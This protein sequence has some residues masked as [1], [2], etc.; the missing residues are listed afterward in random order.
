[1]QDAARPDADQIAELF[2]ELA[3]LDRDQRQRVYLERAVR[4]AVRDEVEA[5]L[6]EPPLAAF[7][8]E[9]LSSAG[10][11]LVGECE[12]RAAP[13]EPG[14]EIG[15]YKIVREIARGGMGVVYEAEQR[16]LTR[17]VALKVIRGARFADDAEQQ[18][19]QVE[20][21]AIARLD[22]SGIVPVYEVAQHDEHPFFTMAYV[23]GGS[24]KDVEVPMAPRPA[25]EL[26][27]K[28]CDAIHYAHTQNIVHRDL[29]PAN[30]LLTE[31]LQP[32]VSDFG[33]AKD[34]EDDSDLTYTGAI[35][36]TPGF[37]APEQAMGRNEA[38]GH[39]A[40]VYGLGGVLFYLLT[41]RP[42][43]EGES[44]P[45]TLHKVV[46]DE[47]PDP[48]RLVASV[49]LDLAGI[50]RKAMEK[51][52]ADRYG[53]A[54]GLAEDLRRYLSGH[55]TVARPLGAMQRAFRWCRRR[56]AI[57]S[58]AALTVIA[59]LVGSITSY[60]FAK[61]AGA[62]ANELQA[63]NK[64]L[65]NRNQELAA[66]RDAATQAQQD[67]ESFSRFLVDDVMRRA[68]PV[69]SV[70]GMG[71]DVT[72]R[73]AL[74]RAIPHLATRF[75]GNPLA[76]ALARSEL[77]IT[78]RH[79]EASQEAV[80]Q[81]KLAH[82][83]RLREL[84][85]TDALTISTQNSLGVA[86][87]DDGRFEDAV[88]VF[89]DLRDIVMAEGHPLL[90]RVLTNLGECYEKQGRHADTLQVLQQARGHAAD[91]V[92]R[93]QL[94]TKLAGAHAR[95]DHR[96]QA[97]GLIDEVRPRLLAARDVQGFERLHIEIGI[98]DAY[99]ALRDRDRLVE[100]L[101]DVLERA[102]ATISPISTE[103]NIM[104][105][106][107]MELYFERD[108]LAA[109]REVMRVQYEAERRLAGN[110]VLEHGELYARLCIMTG[111][112][113]PALDV[114]RFVRDRWLAEQP[115]H[116]GAFRLD[117]FLAHVLGVCGRREEAKQLLLGRLGALEAACAQKPSADLK[118]HLQEF[119][120]LIAK[121]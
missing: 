114:A 60:L 65:G 42:P 81:L 40:D 120:D 37:M 44:L 74:L 99:D 32:K 110:R 68:R 45:E 80:E 2:H 6:G 58:L 46:H 91:E 24:L 34:V 4:E 15:D 49:P 52:P 105:E 64:E 35:L 8:E 28:V 101:P 98:V 117:V 47:V 119:R 9:A 118:L 111:Q 85:P 88:R 86:Y 36:G 92:S 54:A 1:M 89:E 5:L 27:A 77:G 108:Q 107:L 23:A 94:L 61:E 97:Y 90:F 82:A 51:S 75:A 12:D 30:V 66:A 20:A 16:S 63:A 56:P 21:E 102:R 41:G 106:L 104:A 11:R 57:A 103:A 22:H 67:A 55:P 39:L 84:G 83:V 31:S 3:E 113:E 121:L 70:G 19:F 50:C 73:D 116:A 25:A 62:K 38:V 48:R 72:V 78:L 53:S 109:A 93:L 13:W 59:V 29:K 17:R 10:R 96:E 43:I 33:L 112:K 79:A 71:V 69:G 115:T 18:R 14:H 26:V 7:S 87:Q 95:L 76:E 100:F